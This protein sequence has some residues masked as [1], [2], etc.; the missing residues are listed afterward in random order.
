MLQLASKGHRLAI[1]GQVIEIIPGVKPFSPQNSNGTGGAQANTNPEP[2]PPINRPIAGARVEIIESPEAFQ[3]RLALKQLQYGDRWEFLQ[4]RINRTLTAPDGF[5]RFLNLPMGI[6]TL[7][8]QYPKFG[9]SA[10]HPLGNA[11]AQNY[12]SSVQTVDTRPPHH[13][14]AHRL[15][16]TIQLPNFQPDDDDVVDP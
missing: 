7:R 14:E 15:E 11:S 10:I 16:F 12:Y 9:R 5:F 8:A 3:Q 13:T 4:E 1:A 6:Y 2:V